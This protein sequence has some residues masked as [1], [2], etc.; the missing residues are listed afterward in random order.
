MRIRATTRLA[1]GVGSRHPA[2][3]LPMQKVVGSSPIIHSFSKSPAQA[4][5][6]LLK[7]GFYPRDLSRRTRTSAVVTPPFGEGRPRDGAI[8][9]PIGP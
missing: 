4:L 3:S 6:A 5:K 7:S 1:A 2:L 9:R 8:P